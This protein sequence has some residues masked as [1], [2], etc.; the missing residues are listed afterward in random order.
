MSGIN[1]ET[2][3]AILLQIVKDVGYEAGLRVNAYASVDNFPDLRAPAFGKSYEDALE[4]RYWSRDWHHGGKDSA[5][6]VAEFPALFVEWRNVELGHPS[7]LE[8]ST[9]FNLYLVDKIVCDTCPDRDLRT[10]EY[11]TSTTNRTLRMVLRE[12]YSY[13]LYEVDRGGTITWEWISNG[14]AE[15]WESEAIVDGLE[16]ITDLE[17]G[18]QVDP[19]LVKQ[20]TNL[21]DFRVAHTVIKL[22]WCEDD[23]N[24]NFNYQDVVVPALAYTRCPC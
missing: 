4:G 21:P 13:C 15:Y 11:L 6:M 12:L 17:G 3:K 2:F 9:P 7:D 1:P 18:L 5:N 8:G 22:D 14:R 10:P 24:D 16:L 19:I 23:I 20:Y